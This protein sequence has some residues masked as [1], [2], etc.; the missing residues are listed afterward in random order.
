MKSVHS[1]FVKPTKRLRTFPFPKRL[2]PFKR[3]FKNVFTIINYFLYKEKKR[4][5]QLRTEP[6]NVTGNYSI[7]WREHDVTIDERSINWCWH[8][9]MWVLLDQI[10][11][12]STTLRYLCRLS[13]WWLSFKMT[14]GNAR[15][16]RKRDGRFPTPAFCSFSFPL[17]L[18]PVFNFDLPVKVIPQFYIAH[19]YCA[20]FYV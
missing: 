7:K 13:Q 17:P 6:T 11:D 19:L 9:Q 20:E 10:G 3:H 1:L 15:T 12:F 4:R 18:F 2:M 5:L 14:N 16:A 8:S